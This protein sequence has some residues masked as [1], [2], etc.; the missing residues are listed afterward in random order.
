ML[1]FKT[2]LGEATNK[3][4]FNGTLYHGSG[5]RFK[6]FDR[7]KARV[8][9]DYFGGGVAYFTDKLPVAA[10]YARSMAKQSKG[11]PLIYTVEVKLN[12]YFDVDDTFTGLDLVRILPDDVEGFARGAGLLRLNGPDKFVVMTQLKMG[13]ISLSGH[14]VFKGLSK[15]MVTSDAARRFLEKK[16]YDGLRY[17]GGEHM[18]APRHNVYLAY[19]PNSIKIVSRGIVRN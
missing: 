4:T 8:A 13:K 15:G 14:D 12:N 11:D 5:T 18:N 10:T 1:S 9:N 6:E 7:K 2:Y 19:D 17:N 16:G 3:N